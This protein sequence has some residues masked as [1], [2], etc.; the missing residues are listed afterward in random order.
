MRGG[1]PWT[2]PRVAMALP[3]LG[4]PRHVVAADGVCQGIHG[5]TATAFPSGKRYGN[6]K[7]IPTVCHARAPRHAMATAMDG[8][9]HGMPWQ[10]PWQT[11]RHA[12]TGTA[13]NP[14]ACHVKPHGMPRGH[15]CTL[16]KFSCLGMS[17]HAMPRQGPWVATGHGAATAR[18]TVVPR[19]APLICPQQNPAATPTARPASA[20][21]TASPTATPTASP[22]VIRTVIPTGR[23]A[24]KPAARP[25]AP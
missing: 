22:M 13:V 18:A 9:P 12:M 23:P 4:K 11:P 14:T 20:M 15:G 21:P 2:L 10:A 5:V 19:Q 8:K 25:T 24:A 3:W 1:L 16:F 17:W 6:T 7:A